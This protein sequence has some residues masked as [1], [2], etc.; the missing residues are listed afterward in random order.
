MPFILTLVGFV[1]L[2]YMIARFMKQ[3]KSEKLNRLFRVGF[4]IIMG[5]LAFLILVR[6]NIAVGGILGLLSFLSAQ[7][8][9]WTF[10]ASG[11]TQS[12]AARPNLSNSPMTRAEALDILELTGHPG[13]SEIKDAHHRMMLKYHPDQGGS[14]YFASKLNQA[15]DILL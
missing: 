9:L 6:G 8:G 12:S 7:G 5:L 15:R 14:D 4:A 3:S 1:F 2:L 11:P 13:P 10:F